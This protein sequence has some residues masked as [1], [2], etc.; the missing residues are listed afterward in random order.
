MFLTHAYSTITIIVSRPVNTD[1]TSFVAI[2]IHFHNRRAA[3]E[4]CDEVR[5]ELDS[6]GLSFLFDPRTDRLNPETNCDCECHYLRA[7]GC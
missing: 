1:R 3:G 2:W 7:T 4:P 6:A 5:E